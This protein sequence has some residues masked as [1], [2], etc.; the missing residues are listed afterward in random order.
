MYMCVYIYIYMYVYIY[1]YIYIHSTDIFRKRTG[2]EQQR[3]K[4]STRSFSVAT[5]SRRPGAP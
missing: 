3:C 5:C 2:K 4:R 1:I